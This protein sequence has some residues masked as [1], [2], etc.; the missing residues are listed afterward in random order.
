MTYFQKT[1]CFTTH[2]ERN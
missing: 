1:K 2:S